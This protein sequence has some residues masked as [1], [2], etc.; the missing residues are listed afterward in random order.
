MFLFFSVELSENKQ[1][2][3]NFISQF[4]CKTLTT[5]KRQRASSVDP[6]SPSDHLYLAELRV[7]IQKEKDL[8]SEIAFNKLLR[9]YKNHFKVQKE[10]KRR[11]FLDFR[12][13]EDQ[14]IKTWISKHSSLSPFIFLPS[15]TTHF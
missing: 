7:K 15:L 2:I 6:L 3:D 9:E 4:K 5:I 8:E 14:K 12:Y 1:I 10:L 11:A 13:K